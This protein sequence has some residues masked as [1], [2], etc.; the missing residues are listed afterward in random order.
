MQSTKKYI[1]IASATLLGLLAS[2]SDPVDS[3][4]PLEDPVVLYALVSSS[5]NTSGGTSSGGNG[6]SA[7]YAAVRFDSYVSTTKYMYL[8]T[9][10]S[11]SGTYYSYY[12]NPLSAYALDPYACQ[13]VGSSLRLYSAQSTAGSSCASSGLLMT[14]GRCYT[15]KVYSSSYVYVDEGTSCGN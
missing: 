14:A 4:D 13:Y 9:S 1:A 15:I 7:G 3:Y 2:C 11:C 6:C 8:F 12:Y 10:S 5:A